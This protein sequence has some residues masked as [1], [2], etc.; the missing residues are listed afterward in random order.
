ME[1]CAFSVDIHYV[2]GT[3]SKRIG[4]VVWNERVEEVHALCM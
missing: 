3:Y 4:K 1:V 2:H